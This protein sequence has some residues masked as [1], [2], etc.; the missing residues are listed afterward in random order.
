[1]EVYKSQLAEGMVRSFGIFKSF[2]S[3]VR[4]SINY[5]P[6]VLTI[7][8]LSKTVEKANKA[9]KRGCRSQPHYTETN[10]KPIRRFGFNEI[11][12]KIQLIQE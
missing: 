1:M 4:S 8:S 5:P 9:M 2:S 10:T 7:P 3:Q 12:D 11:R 6:D